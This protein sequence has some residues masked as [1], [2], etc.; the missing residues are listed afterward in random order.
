[1]QVL[2]NSLQYITRDPYVRWILKQNGILEVVE[3][4]IFYP[5]SVHLTMGRMG[6]LR[7]NLELTCGYLPGLS[8]ECDLQVRRL[9]QHLKLESWMALSSSGLLLRTSPITSLSHESTRKCLT[10][11]MMWNPLLIWS[12]VVTFFWHGSGI[13]M[14]INIVDTRVGTIVKAPI[15]DQDPST[16][17]RVPEFRLGWD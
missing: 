14:L 3:K 8:R 13:E 5:L 9:P 7:L 15:P 17:Y 4:D 6:H 2:L 10:F 11:V 1:M 16:I 12:F